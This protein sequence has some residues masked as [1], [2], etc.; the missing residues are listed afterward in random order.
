M[1]IPSFETLPGTRRLYATALCASALCL[2]VALGTAAMAALPVP[3]IPVKV[4]GIV[5][6]G[7]DA[8]SLS[9]QVVVMPRLIVDGVF[10]R[11]TV[12]ELVIDFSGVKGVRRANPSEQFV[13]EAQTIVRRPLLVRDPVEVTFLY[14]STNGRV[15]KAARAILDV[16]YGAGGSLTIVSTLNDVAPN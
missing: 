3:A 13:S 14:R 12:L 5:G 6:T 15:I 1:N 2:P 11:R 9:G 8:V 7:V 16:T 10:T 4:G